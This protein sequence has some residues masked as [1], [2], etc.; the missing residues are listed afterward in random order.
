M[1]QRV[2]FFITKNGQEK[3]AE[4]KIFVVV[5]FAVIPFC[6]PCIFFLFLQPTANIF[7]NQSIS[8]LSPLDRLLSEKVDGDNVC[9]E[10]VSQVSQSSSLANPTQK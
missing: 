9:E 7:K 1:F 4:A 3:Y 5:K 6:K 2:T 10:P 8:F